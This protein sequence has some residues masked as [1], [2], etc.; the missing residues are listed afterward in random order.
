[1]SKK[2]KEKDFHKQKQTGKISSDTLPKEQ[3]AIIQLIILTMLTL[4]C[5]AP[6]ADKAFNI[7]DPLFLWTARQIQN[8]PADFYGFL[9][10]WEKSEMPMHEVTKN[11]PLT[12]YYIALV[13][14]LIG[15]SEI[16]LHFAFLI[17]AIAVAL[18]TY[19]LARQFC[20]K[21]VV[22]SL[23]GMLTPVFLIS[24]TSVMC[25][26]MMLAFWVWAVFFW[27]KGIES[28]KFSQLFLAS[29]FIAAS[30][31]TKYFGMSLIPLLLIYSLVKKRRIGFW[32]LFLSI[33]VII[34]A[35]YQWFT[36]MLYGKGLLSDA[37]S[38]ASS[39]RKA[40]GTQFLHKGIIGLAFTGGCLISVLFYSTLLWSRRLLTG[41]V[42]LA[43]VSVFILSS[44]K[45]IGLYPLIDA[46][47]IRWDIVI[48]LSIFAIGG[49]SL[50]ALTVIDFWKRRDAVS[51]LLFLW[52]FGTFIFA[53][54]INWTINARSIL[55]I[56]PA[57][58]IIV[59]RRI[60]HISKHLQSKN[61]WHVLWPLIPAA[62]ISLFVTWADY[63][64]ANTARSA[65]A[66]ILREYDNRAGNVWFEGHWGFQY[67]M[68]SGGGKAIDITQSHLTHG[69]VV[70]IPSN[71]DNIYPLPDEIVSLEKEIQVVPCRWLSTSNYFAG[72]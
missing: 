13:A 31:L 28:E 68:E 39:V 53:T 47:T 64:L 21:P 30:A 70:I 54:F 71:N 8:H 11:P 33:P 44:I 43:G 25:D 49:L 29:L 62:V 45:T 72:A 55:P 19:F 5:L 6:F 63:T 60:D 16:A 7:D 15:W 26:T 32:L 41:G 4:I 24:S 42:I 10:N 9:V 65:A 66:Q 56:V 61:R 35:G 20:M 57:A 23:A 22:A 40:E 48:H 51:L 2:K 36:H 3:K 58:G 50:L 52:I 34:L 37:A 12:A 1:M 69:D 14:S 38:Y 27:T 18:G 17:P 46:N 59:A 67:Y